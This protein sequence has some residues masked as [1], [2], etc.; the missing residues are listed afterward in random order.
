M[1]TPERQ[2]VFISYAHRDG[3]GIAVRLRRDLET[4]GFD[5]WLDT[6]RLLGGD[7]WARDIEIA[8]DSCDIALALLSNGSFHSDI[9][10][11]E[12]ERSLA[13]G[14]LVIPARLQRDCDVPLVLQTRH[15]VDFSDAENYSAALEQL[16]ESIRQRRGM[17]QPA[18]TRLH[19]NNAPPLPDNFVE[20]PGIFTALRDALFQEAPNRNIALT[21]LQ[22]MGGIGKTVLAQALC[23]NEV[24]RHAFP[25]GIF[26]FTIG[27]ESRLRFDQRIEGVPGLKQLLGAYNGEEAC[28]SQYRNALRDKAALIVLDDVW[29]AGDVEPFHIESSRSRLLITTRDT[30]IAPAFGAREFTVD[31]LTHSEACLVLACWAGI[32]P[33]A[34]PTKA[35]ALI[36]ECGNLPLALAMTGAQLKGKPASH[37]ERVLGHFRR[38]D[39]AKIKSLFPEPHTTLFRSIQV[40]FEAL[41]EED[42]TAAQRYL[43]LA[44]ILEDMDVTPAVQQTLWKVNEAEAF[45]TADHFVGLS[46]AQQVGG[47]GAIRLHDLQLDYIRAQYP[48]RDALE[49]IHGAVRLSSHVLDDD[50]SQ[51]SSQVVGRLLL[52]RQNSTIQRFL[53]N[54]TAGAP[55]PWLRPLQA[56]LI[57]PGE[58]LVRTLVGHTDAVYRV[59]VTPDGER[60]VS[61]SL[62][63]TLK[64]WDLEAGRPL[65][66]LEGH[67]DSVLDIAVTA[68]GS[69][70]V[71]ACLDGTLKVWDLDTGRSL[72]TLEGHSGCVFGVAVTPDGKRAVS[73]SKDRTL[74]VWD[75]DTGRS[76]RT[77][78]GHSADVDAVAVTADG[79]RVVSASSDATLRVWDLD[80]G[81]A[82]LAL[83]GHSALVW[84]VAVTL[85]GKRAI[86]A[87]GDRSLKVW[88]LDTGR[89]LHTLEGHSIAATGVAVTPDGNRAVSASGDSTLKVWDLETGSELYTL[90][91][92][93]NYVHGV[94]LTPDGKRVVSASGDK[95]LKV[96]KLEIGRPLPAKEGHSAQ[97]NAVAVTADGQRVVSA[98][99]D[100]TLKVWDFETGCALRTLKGHTSSVSAVAVTPDGKRVVSAS[101]D[102]TMKTWDLET[103]RALRT[104]NG[105]AGN[106][107]KEGD[108]RIELLWLMHVVG[109]ADDLWG[110]AVTRDAKRVVSASGDKTLKVWDLETGR[111]LRTLEGH[112]DHVHGV[113]VTPDGKWAVS[114]SRDNM[115]K[116]WDLETGRELRTLVG[117]SDRVW[118]VAVTPDG[119][120][121]V[122]ASWDGTLKLWDLAT[123]RGLL[124]LVG[125]SGLV[126]CVAVTPGGERAV[127]ASHDGTLKVW[128]LAT[129]R[130]AVTFHC[131]APATCC[132]FVDGQRIVAGDQGGRM[133]FL[134]LEMAEGP[135]E[136]RAVRA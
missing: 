129:G 41:K 73:A 91:G 80:T 46:L 27:K 49:L 43:A 52:Y 116:L 5:V 67:S 110:V 55:V 106:A 38:A 62:D 26:W 23:L 71:S 128:E 40:S 48:D 103:G 82:L 131:D 34:L 81:R 109:P 6:D 84:S 127:S 44:V 2:R 130:C 126:N 120:R 22:G 8:I 132:T 87:S 79:K 35:K 113:A 134:S 51:F 10:R 31:L 4:L 21:A 53:N 119:K 50:S 115:L 88:N 39:L 47:G 29:R 63:K 105:H 56:A 3:G 124:T 61:A 45:E 85:D 69:R 98:S 125:H 133:Y 135:D 68:D 122:S 37:W 117:H 65:R 111:A 24:V 11:A 95:T 86:S 136:R 20:R 99:L 90:E 76:L 64:V 32:P 16:E 15:Y 100:S 93:T 42:P 104:L 14:K 121:A 123:G 74:K 36:H 58:P 17:V 57:S 94:A 114:A 83:E 19:Y 7:V 13:K 75:L 102:N 28:V 92:H 33:R 97:I 107:L 1:S 25:D 101:L 66:T 12:Q 60:A 77:L 9:C 118:G 112:S 89:S 108:L 30:G 96:W 70:A 59:A 18:L 72:R 78:K 54:I